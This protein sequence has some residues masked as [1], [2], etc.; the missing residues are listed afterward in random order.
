MP[1]PAATLPPGVA[2]ASGERDPR[3]RGFV[4]R[5]VAWRG[6]CR[7]A[8]A[9]P[10]AQSTCALRPAATLAHTASRDG[11]APR[12]PRWPAWRAK[13]LPADLRRLAVLELSCLQSVRRAAW[14]VNI[15]LT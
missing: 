14:R 10:K 1:P 5:I 9:R 12:A 2:P 4:P 8:R 3:P 6:R 7:R 11:G 13:T 15:Y